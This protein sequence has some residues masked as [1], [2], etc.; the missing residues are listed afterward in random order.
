MEH[1][2][3]NTRPKNKCV[4]VHEILRLIIMKMKMKMKKDYRDT[5][6]I[7]LGLDMD[8]NIVNIRSASV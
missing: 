1:I 5:T 3:K 7:D 4:Y 2:L 6:Q 8:T